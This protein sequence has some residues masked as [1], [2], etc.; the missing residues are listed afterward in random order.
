MTVPEALV[1]YRFRD[2]IHGSFRQTRL[3]GRYQARV[4]RD[5]PEIVPPRGVRLA[6]REWFDLLKA[7]AR[8]RHRSDAARCA[9][10]LGYSVGRLGGSVRYR[11]LYL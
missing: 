2:S 7:L 5:F 10:R 1:R 11:V 4:Y 9:V 8:A 6:L 3:W